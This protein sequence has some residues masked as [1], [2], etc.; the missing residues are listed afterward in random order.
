MA[1]L[2]HLSGSIPRESSWTIEDLLEDP[3]AG[4]PKNEQM[5]R[6]C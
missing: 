6:A 3:V 1:I 2:L 4:K 5:V